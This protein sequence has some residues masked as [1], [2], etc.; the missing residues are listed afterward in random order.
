MHHRSLYPS[1]RRLVVAQHADGRVE[2]APELWHTLVVA[3]AP[4]GRR[5]AMDRA[6]CS[7]C[8]KPQQRLAIATGDCAC[9]SCET[10]ANQ[11]L[12]RGQCGVCGT[13]F[14]DDPPVEDEA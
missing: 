9:L 8:H 1:K 6:T 2:I 3:L 14:T 4:S 10:C 5:S 11:F 7:A 12:E 13:V